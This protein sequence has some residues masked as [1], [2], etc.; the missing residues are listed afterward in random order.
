MKILLIAESQAPFSGWGTYAK[1]MLQGLQDAGKDVQ[2]LDMNKGLPSPLSL[3]DSWL[4]QVRAAW[5]IA[6]VVRKE[7]PDVIHVLVEPYALALPLAKK[8]CSLP[9]W[10]MNFHGTYSVTPHVVQRTKNTMRTALK[11][12][13]AFLVCSDYTQNQ[14]LNVLPESVHQGVLNRCHP[15]RLA[16]GTEPRPQAHGNDILFVGG[17]K[18]RKGVQEL[19]H[20]FLAYKQKYGGGSKLHIVGAYK[21][22]PYTDAMSEATEQAGLSEDVYLHGKIEQQ[23]L[24]TLY[25]TAGAFAMLSQHDGYNYEGYGLAFLEANVYGIPCISSQESGGRE[26]VLDGKTGYVV[27]HRNPDEV[28]G[29]LH[30]ILNKKSIN[31]SDCIDWANEHNITQQTATCTR[32]YEQIT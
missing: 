16:V 9:P 8:L 13:T 18:L 10:V 11:Q 32:L 29:A 4:C 14:V 1:N 21:D 30:K 31:P 17:V 2:L 23:E 27:D 20:G 15:I 6:S 7:K 12:C 5:K 19:V 25:E 26:A 3:M 24:D 28:A 22:G